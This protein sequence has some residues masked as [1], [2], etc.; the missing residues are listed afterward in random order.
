MR[1]RIS[2]RE[3]FQGSAD[4][5]FIFDQMFQID[6]LQ[7]LPQPA[8]DGLPHRANTAIAVLMAA[9]GVFVE[10]VAGVLEGHA[11]KDLNNLGDGDIGRC[12]GQRKTAFCS[13]LIEK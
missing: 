1:V 4:R 7:S 6:A 3:G 13:A 5:F 12:F 10:V 2:Y 9:V 11:F 8:A